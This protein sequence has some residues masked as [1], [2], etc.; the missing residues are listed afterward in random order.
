MSRPDGKNG[1]GKPVPYATINHRGTAFAAFGR[2]ISRPDVKACS[3]ARLLFFRHRHATPAHTPTSAEAKRAQTP[4]GRYM[5]YLGK[6]D[7]HAL[8]PRPAA[9]TPYSA[10]RDKLTL[11]IKLDFTSYK[12]Y[13]VYM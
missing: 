9:Y 13:N 8:R 5:A 10:T 7:V 11:Q 4:T 3:R 1:T 6:P 2:Y 12:I